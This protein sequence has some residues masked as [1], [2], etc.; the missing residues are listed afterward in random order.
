MIIVKSKY[1]DLPVGNK[2]LTL[3]DLNQNQ[4]QSYKDRFGDKFFENLKK[5]KKEKKQKQ[6]S[7][8]GVDA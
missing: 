4:L 6:E 2:K 5:E 7:N 3:G 1:L 8:Y